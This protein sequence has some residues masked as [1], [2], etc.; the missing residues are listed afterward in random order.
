MG[1]AQCEVVWTRI[2]VTKAPSVTQSQA[3]GALTGSNFK[4]TDTNS[5]GVV[6]RAEFLVACN[7]GRERHRRWFQT[8]RSARDPRTEEV[9]SLLDSAW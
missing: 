5:D 2:N 8:Y 9:A 1:D 6:S 4:T 3:E 7:E